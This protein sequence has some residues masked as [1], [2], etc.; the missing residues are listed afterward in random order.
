MQTVVGFHFRDGF[1]FDFRPAFCQWWKL[2][3]TWESN[4]HGNEILLAENRPFSRY[5]NCDLSLKTKTKTKTTDELCWTWVPHILM[6]QASML[7]RDI[8][9]FHMH[10]R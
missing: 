6:S 5:I 10:T 1:T 3:L 8:P 4:N 9:T 7:Y 2:T